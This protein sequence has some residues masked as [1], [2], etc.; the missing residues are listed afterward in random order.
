MLIEALSSDPSE[1]RRSSAAQFLEVMA[2]PAALPALEK[3]TADP[4]KYVRRDAAETI[5][6]LRKIKKKS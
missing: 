6:A 2:D 3:A 1:L 4:D 5:A